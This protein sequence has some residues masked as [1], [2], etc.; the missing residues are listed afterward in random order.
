MSEITQTQRMLIRDAFLK[1][2]QLEKGPF[3]LKGRG[4]E[5]RVTLDKQVA[6][7]LRG[8]DLPRLYIS[9]YGANF[10]YPARLIARAAELLLKDK[11]D[12]VLA[13]YQNSIYITTKKH[14]RS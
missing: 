9:G 14:I 13:N 11:A 12:L 7:I 4:H 6:A 1:A 5:P 2:M 10:Y 8:V 3:N